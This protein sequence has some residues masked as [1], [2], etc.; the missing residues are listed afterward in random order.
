MFA[1]WLLTLNFSKLQTGTTFEKGVNC[2]E[3]PDVLQENQKDECQDDI[4]G[5]PGNDVVKHDHVRRNKSD[6]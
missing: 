2:A 6:N 3:N 5:H 4:P 1:L